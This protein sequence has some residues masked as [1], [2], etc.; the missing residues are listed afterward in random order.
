MDSRLFFYI[1]G[2]GKDYVKVMWEDALHLDNV[3]YINSPMKTKYKGKKI[4]DF[5]ESKLYSFR[6]NLRFNLPGKAIWRKDYSFNELKFDNRYT[7]VVVFSD[8]TR[9]LSDVSYWEEK[10][11]KNH[12]IYCVL[13]LN[14]CRHDL[15]KDNKEIMRILDFLPVDY[16]YTFDKEDAR[17]FNLDYF[18]SMLSKISNFRDNCSNLDYDFYFIGQKKNRFADI[19]NLYIKLTSLGYKCLFRV[20]GVDEKEQKK[21]PG[22]IYNDPI[23][24]K[25]MIEELNLSKCIVDIKV[26]EQNGLSLRFFEAVIYNKLLLTNNESIKYEPLYNSTYMLSYSNVEELFFEDSFINQIPD[27]HY[28]KVK[29]YSPITFLNKLE[30]RI[31]N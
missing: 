4:F 3:C 15:S 22:I 16:I 23:D 5:I 21:C 31:E 27:Y 6:I 11:E 14:N 24:Y 30:K 8:I 9:L 13:L 17:T 10:K 2:T 12:L 19:I 1:I 26:P 20:T 28:E 29:C 25:D 18:P 7:N